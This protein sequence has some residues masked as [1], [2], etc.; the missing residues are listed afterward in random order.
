MDGYMRHDW[1]YLKWMDGYMKHETWP[2][3]LKWMDGYMKHA[4]LI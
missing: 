4:R 1:L 3:D 2:I